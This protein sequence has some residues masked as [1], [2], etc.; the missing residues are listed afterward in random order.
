MTGPDRPLAGGL[1]SSSTARWRLAL[2]LQGRLLALRVAIVAQHVRADRCWRNKAGAGDLNFRNE[3]KN[4]QV[5]P[6]LTTITGS[7][8]EIFAVRSL[9]AG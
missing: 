6:T 9:R 2:V 1:I 4:P 3:K 7:R 5:L 8:T